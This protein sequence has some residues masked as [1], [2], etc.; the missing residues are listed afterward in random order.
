MWCI[1]PAKLTSPRFPER[2]HSTSETAQRWGCVLQDSRAERLRYF[3]TIQKNILK[4]ELQV[5]SGYFFPCGFVL[6][7]K[8]KFLLSCSS[9]SL[10]QV[11]YWK[12]KQNWDHMQTE[13]PQPGLN[14]RIWYHDVTQS[15]NFFLFQ[16]QSL[17]TFFV[18]C[19]SVNNILKCVICTTFHWM[20]VISEG[21]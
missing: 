6:P 11:C 17:K 9:R 20:T 1:Q 18:F 5:L 12:T 21:N 13:P 15:V 16:D 2:K 3:C 19:C 4:A 10:I 14:L 8:A 7:D